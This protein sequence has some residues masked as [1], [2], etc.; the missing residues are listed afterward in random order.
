MDPSTCCI[1]CSDDI[2]GVMANI[3]RAIAM[4]VDGSTKQILLFKQM[5]ST[6]KLQRS[7][8]IAFSIHHNKEGF[9]Y[10]QNFPLTLRVELFNAF[11]EPR[12]LSLSS[13][14]VPN[15][16]ASICTLPVQP[17]RYLKEKVSS[18]RAEQ[19]SRSCRV[20]VTRCCRNIT[21]LW[22]SPSAKGSSPS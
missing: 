7:R 14:Q 16:I 19:E 20:H 2:C 22:C 15:A 1:H 3:Y 12:S 6:T 17:S 9:R 10:F 21:G 8:I 5:Q 18:H 11:S 13:N 4:S